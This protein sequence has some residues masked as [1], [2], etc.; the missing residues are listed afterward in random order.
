MQRPGEASGGDGEGGRSGEAVRDQVEVAKPA[1]ERGG[2]EVKESPHTENR[3][4]LIEI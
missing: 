2:E 4:T 1:V 3:G